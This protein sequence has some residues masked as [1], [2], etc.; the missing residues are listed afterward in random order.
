ME[1]SLRFAW[2]V[3]ASLALAARAEAQETPT[4]SLSFGG[5]GGD[6][7]VPASGGGS[8]FDA[9][10]NVMLEA[11]ANPSEEGAQGWSISLSAGGAIAVTGI[12]TVG[13]PGRDL[14]SGGFEKTEV[15]T[16]DR[17][18]GDCAGAAGAV[19]AV[20]LSFTKAITLPADGATAIG[21]VTVG[22][23]YPDAPAEGEPANCAP[24]SLF[25]VD[26]CRG[27]GQRV[28]NNITWRGMTV[29]PELG[30]CDFNLCTNAPLPVPPCDYP[31]ADEPGYQIVVQSE[32]LG[33]GVGPAEVAGDALAGII[34]PTRE[35]AGENCPVAQ[36]CKPVPAD[37]ESTVN[38]YL[39]ISSNGES[40]VQGWSLSVASTPSGLTLTGATTAGTVGARV[41]V[42][43][44]GLQSGGFEKTETV[45]P[46]KNAQ[47]EGAVSAVVLS[48][49]KPVTLAP[50]GTATVLCLE[51][52]GTVAEG[53]SKTAL[54]E[55]RDGLQGAGQPVQSVATVLGATEE[56]FNF[57]SVEV[58][59]TG[60]VAPVEVGPFRRCDPNNDGRNNLA[61]AI[62]LINELFRGGVPSPCQASADCDNNDRVDLNDAIFAVTYQF[63]GGAAPDAPFPDCGVT[64]PGE[65]GCKDTTACNG[66]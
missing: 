57:Q 36:I 23:T 22:G 29:D 60:E 7:T 17:N 43:P 1:R 53:E 58:K 54:I 38:V 51:L 48:F 18:E 49:T 6:S 14:Q 35:E 5:C 45:D 33:G 42:D 37:V 26:G 28:E 61:D 47:G 13:T 52:T 65:L 21:V 44:A 30:A 11:S 31:R 34:T 2:I 50:V 63:L 55:G 24:A 8:A 4:F 10:Y 19:S 15:T 20:V 9:S 3:A 62:F 59:L 40:G 27:A 41:G 25:F 66:V 39:A 64:D 12:T 32:P 46:T 16:A 56:F